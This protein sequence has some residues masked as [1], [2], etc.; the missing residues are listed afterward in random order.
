MRKIEGYI[1]N[2]VSLLSRL[3]LAWIFIPSG[4]GKL[5]NLSGVT[6]YFETLGIPFHQTA[7]P[8]VAGTELIAGVLILVGFFARL[9]SLPLIVIMLVAILTAKREDLESF[10]DLLLFPE[11]LIALVLIWLAAFG[12]GKW[13]LSQMNRKL[14]SSHVQ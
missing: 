10:G 9:A 13:S 6:G 5:N 8:L 2:L 4:W 11:F 3:A 12:A 14:R 1:Q 7:A